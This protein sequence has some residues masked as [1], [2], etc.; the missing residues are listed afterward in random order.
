MNRLKFYF[1]RVK[2]KAKKP[3][4]KG[5]VA[6]A[7]GLMLCVGRTW[8]ALLPPRRAAGPPHL[9]AARPTRRHYPWGA[10]AGRVRKK[11]VLKAGADRRRIK[12]GAKGV[13]LKRYTEGVC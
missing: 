5:V 4:G 11:G 8:G 1:I 12:M 13:M 10:E 9:A 3:N 6:C 2:G 7:T